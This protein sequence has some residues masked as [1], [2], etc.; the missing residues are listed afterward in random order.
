[1]HART[2]NKSKVL[3]YYS[4]LYQVLYL[5]IPLL[6][7]QPTDIQI[8]YNKKSNFKMSKHV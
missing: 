3:D 6:C 7:V 5:P 2:K 4:N 1:M 8:E